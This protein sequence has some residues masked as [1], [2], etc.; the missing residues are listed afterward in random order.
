[1]LLFLGRQL[2]R[3][4]RLEGLLS[5]IFV[6]CCGLPLHSS[7]GWPYRKSAGARLAAGGAALK[8]VSTAASKAAEEARTGAW[9]RQLES[10][11][12]AKSLAPGLEYGLF[13]AWAS[14]LSSTLVPSEIPCMVHITCIVLTGLYRSPC[15]YQLAVMRY[16]CRS[17]L[18]FPSICCLRAV[19]TMPF[20]MACNQWLAIFAELHSY[21]QNSRSAA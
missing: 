11:R 17:A 3:Q 6:C 5:Q 1:M 20:M 16:L 9:L 2:I 18:Q 8:P 14:G 7:P 15:S 12:N 19:C 13:G 10:G 21:C 4:A